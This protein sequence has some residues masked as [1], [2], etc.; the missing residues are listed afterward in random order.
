[1]YSPGMK[2]DITLADF[3]FIENTLGL[4]VIS[5]KNRTFAVLFENQVIRS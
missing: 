2:E 4:P 5:P 3:L 1:M